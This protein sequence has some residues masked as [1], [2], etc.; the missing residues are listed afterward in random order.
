M[1]LFSLGTVGFREHS[2]LT[3]PAGTLRSPVPGSFAENT[4]VSSG[5][6]LA[7]LEAP[8]TRQIVIGEPPLSNTFFSSLPVKNPTQRPSGE[9]NGE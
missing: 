6:Q 8:P 5:P 4:I 7:P 3:A 1:T 2:W 9:K